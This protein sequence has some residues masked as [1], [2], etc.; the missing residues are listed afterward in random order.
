MKSNL[1]MAALVTLMALAACDTGT[2]PAA[3]APTLT[4]PPVSP[5]TF[6]G[7]WGTASG[8]VGHIVRGP[9]YITVSADW[10]FVYEGGRG[11]FSDSDIFNDGGFSQAGIL[12]PAPFNTYYY[13]PIIVEGNLVYERDGYYLFAPSDGRIDLRT[14]KTAAV[15][16]GVPLLADALPDYIELPGMTVRNF[17]E[18]VK[19]S[20][21]PGD[22]LRLDM[23]DD[24]VNVNGGIGFLK[25]TWDKQP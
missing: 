8:S 2:T 4:L 14:L 9:R 20:Y 15:A 18:Y 24:P 11:D 12:L 16:A 6:T 23:D 13:P 5:I 7:E 10:S 22:A 21:I 3:A 1:L 25:G 19:I 17:R